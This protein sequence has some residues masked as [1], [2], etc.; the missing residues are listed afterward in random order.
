MSQLHHRNVLP[1]RGVTYQFG[2]IPC[3]VTPLMS[4]GP[5][6]RYIDHNHGFISM[7]RRFAIVSFLC[8]QVVKTHE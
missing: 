1:L 6:T 5:L 3:L 8:Q 2:S 7:E 4:E